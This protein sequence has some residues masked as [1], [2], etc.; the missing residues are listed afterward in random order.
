MDSELPP[1]SLE[2]GSMWT[3]LM[4]D[5]MGRAAARSIPVELLSSGYP[6]QT[7]EDSGRLL[8]W[9]RGWNQCQDN[10]QKSEWKEEEV[11]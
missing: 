11:S 1:S 10:E 3:Q 8:A 5:L 7:L 9:K 6:A 2:T 4:D